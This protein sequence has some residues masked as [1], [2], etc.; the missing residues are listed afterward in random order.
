MRQRNQ[1]QRRRR[2]IQALGL[3]NQEQ[4]PAQARRQHDDDPVDPIYTLVVT[5]GLPISATLKCGL[6][7]TVFCSLWV[8][9][10]CC[11]K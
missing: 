3:E 1:A 10:R 8:F 7:S 11:I 9:Y 2:D 4:Q 5:A 6:C